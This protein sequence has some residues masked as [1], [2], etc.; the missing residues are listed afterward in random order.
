MAQINNM[1]WYHLYYIF[2]NDIREDKYVGL[3]HVAEHTLLAPTD[4][5]LNF[6]AQ[7]YTCLN[8]VCLYFGSKTLEDLQEIDRKIIGGQIITEENVL[9][10]KSQVIEEISRLRDKT[11]RFE[12]LVSFVTENRIQ[13]SAIGDTA[14]VENIQAQDILN[15]F[16]FKQKRGQ[17][18]RFLFK[19]AHNMIVSSPFSSNSMKKRA[20]KTI[21]NKSTCA[22]S[23]LYE[24]LPDSASTIQIYFQIP[25]LYSRVELVKKALYEFCIR[26]KVQDSLG[27]VMNITDNYFD[28]DERY[29]QM[30]FPWSPKFDANNLLEKLRAAINSITA[31]EYQLYRNEF[32]DYISMVMSQPEANSDIINAIK[33]TIIYSVPRVTLA[34]VKCVNHDDIGVFPKEWITSR[35][36]KA[37]VL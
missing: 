24:T 7:G 12:N 2:D 37:V 36:I 4:I 19:D 16:V 29:I 31:T 26:R 21:W 3:S 25:S 14:E 23:V 15:W 5:G 18:Y 1:A 20:G 9:C 17:I 6:I 22:D 28:T 35:S 34:D 10:A 13:K 33:N 30:Y 11:A 27:I 8:H 32:M